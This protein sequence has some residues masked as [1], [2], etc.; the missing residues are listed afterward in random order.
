KPLYYFATPTTLVFASE[1]RALLASG[2]V[3]RKLS[4]DGVASYLESGAI[5]SPLSIIDGVRSLEP[6]S[7][8]V[9]KTGKSG[10][11]LHQRSFG[12]AILPAA[13]DSAVTDRPEAV[14]LLRN[15]LE[16]SVRHHLVSDVPVAAFLSGGIDSS[17]VV[18]LMGQVTEE[19]PKT[20]TVVFQEKD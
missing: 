17:A 7:C 12:E 8:L 10:L 3:P 1:I 2:I 11:E 14:Q 18:A 20:F 13:T 6:G 15:K 19:R 16:D 9:A 5:Q 4:V